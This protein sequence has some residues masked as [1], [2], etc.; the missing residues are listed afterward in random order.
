M[1]IGFTYGSYG[2][3]SFMLW[4]LRQGKVLSDLYD[5]DSRKKFEIEYKGDL[6]VFAQNYDEIQ[7]CNKKIKLV[8]NDNALE[9]DTRYNK[10]FVTPVD[11][12]RT[13]Y[14][15]QKIKEFLDNGNLFLSMSN[16]SFQ[17][18]NFIFQ[19]LFSFVYHYYQLGYKFLNYYQNK[20]KKNLL[21][22]YHKVRHIGGTI[23][24]RRNF[25]INELKAIL[26]EDFITYK[27]PESD[28]DLL[29]DS[30]RYFGQW[31]NVHMSGYSDYTTSVCNLTME[32]YDSLGSYVHENRFLLT[33][34][35]LK[36]LL[37]SAEDIFFLWYGHES[38]LPCL[39]DYGFWFL[40][41]E[42]YEPGSTE[43]TNTAMLKSIFKTTKYLKDLKIEHGSNENVHKYL[44]EKYGEKLR[45]NTRLFDVLLHNCQIGDNIIN[46]IKNG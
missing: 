3:A 1:K 25:I 34:K 38:F 10:I 7:D 12:I 37:Y 8:S 30:Y 31:Y 41:F 6:F 22:T 21:G 19:P 27:S 33:E 36:G 35:T 26:G 43:G 32:T 5:K 15:D 9:E 44:L 42:F 17:H 46:L 29:L 39:Q 40:N 2:D 28:F 11:T 14:T 20:E 24:P 18:P 16:L 4:I 13:Q 45:N 23:Y